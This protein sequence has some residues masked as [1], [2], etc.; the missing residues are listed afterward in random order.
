MLWGGF[1]ADEWIITFPVLLWSLGLTL[2]CLA[3]LE[4]SIMD[5]HGFWGDPWGH[6]QS[7]TD[8]LLCRRCSP[9]SSSSSADGETFSLRME[10]HVGALP[11]GS[12]IVLAVQPL[13][14]GTFP[15]LLFPNRQQL[16]LQ[17]SP[18]CV[19]LRLGS[20]LPHTV[21]TG[22][23]MTALNKLHTNVASFLS[24]WI[25]SLTVSFSVNPKECWR[26]CLGTALGR[27]RM[28]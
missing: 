20:C 7:N 8:V 1:Y 24:I 13:V 28:P 18:W 26:G 2:F 12:L 17:S 19:T 9:L 23:G 4:K 6:G 11:L 5:K 3:E 22:G 25:C 10:H 16:C 21:P 15:R 27:R 14:Y